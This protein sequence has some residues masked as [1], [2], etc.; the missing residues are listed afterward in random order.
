M[1]S[2]E[3]KG[4]LADKHV[5]DFFMTE[6]KNGPTQLVEQG[7][8]AILDALA[9]RKSWVNPLFIG[10]EVK[11]SRQD[12]MRDTKWHKYLPLVHQFYFVCPPGIIQPEELE[13]DV[14]LMYATAK[15]FSV[16]KRAPYRNIEIDSL[17]LMY[18]IMNK[19]D[20]DRTPFYS[21]KSSF[22]QQWLDNKI[23]TTTLGYRVSSE[24]VKRLK[25]AEKLAESVKEAKEKSLTLDKVLFLLKSYGIDYQNWRYAR[26]VVDEEV[27]RTSLQQLTACSASKDVVS[28]AERLSKLLSEQIEKWKGSEQIEDGS[29]I[30]THVGD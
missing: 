25:E 26:D 5:K 2:Y 28:Q 15:T 9:I 7:G 10:Y 17:M 27:L 11:V 14:G 4:R 3:I 12:F 6:V 18:I 1:T 19:I 8:L 24:L 16:K 22:F 13:P 30:S 21:E 29:R 23:D 20:S